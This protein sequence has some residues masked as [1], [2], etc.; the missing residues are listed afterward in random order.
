MLGYRAGLALVV[1]TGVLVFL[2]TSGT[3][4]VP[5][6]ATP[7]RAAPTPTPSSQEPAV[8]RLADEQPSENT[9]VI[10]PDPNE[11]PVSNQAGPTIEELLTR[12]RSLEADRKT[13]SDEK[14][15][16]LLLNLDILS[17]AEQ[18]S[19][20][21][22]KQ[23]FDMIDKESNVRTKIDQIDTDMRPEA[24]ERNVALAGSLR[25]EELRANRRKSFEL[26]K[27]NLQNLLNEITKTKASLELNLQRADALVE[28]LRIKLERDIENALDE[29]P[30]VILN[31]PEN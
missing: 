25:P 13:D 31:N 2:G 4:Q 6:R 28:K 7:R 19:E 24:I 16:R 22:R 9:I 5:Q 26:E 3:A 23:L 12:I 17:R 11:I 27:A 14:R 30:E 8:I 21:L 10:G 29:E 1:L 18:R 15:K 20:S